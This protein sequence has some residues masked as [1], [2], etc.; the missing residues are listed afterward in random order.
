MAANNQQT[1]LA[2]IA[3][4]AANLLAYR[5]EWL[6]HDLVAGLSVAAVAAPIAVA[7]AD[8]AGFSPV[9]GLYASILPLVVYALFGTSRHLIVNPDAAICAMV[10]AILAPFAAHNTEVYSALSV[11]L[12]LLTG[13]L[14]IVAGFLRLGFVADFLGK[15]VLVGYMNGMAISI[16]LG[17][18]GKVCGFPIESER[19]VPRLVEFASK[20]SQTHLPTLAIGSLTFILIIGMRRYAPKLPAPLIAVSIAVALCHQFQLD[21]KGVLV[22]GAVPAG[23]PSLRL[24][25]FPIEH[26]DGFLAAAVGLALISFSS[27][28]IAARMFAGRQHTDLNVDREFVALGLCNIA[29]GF[30][31]GFA[32][33][34][35]DSRTA[36]NYTMGGKSQLSGLVAALVMASVLLFLT[37]LLRYFPIAALGAVLIVAAIGLVDIFSLRHLWHVSRSEFA[38][39][40]ITM[41]G[42]VAMDVLGGIL[43]AVGVAL[44]LLL[45]R[46]SRPGDATLGRVAGL[47]GFYAIAEEPNATMHQGLVIYRFE[48]AIVFFNAPYFRR[49]VLEIVAA[50]NHLKWLIVDGGPL[51]GVDTTGADMLGTLAVELEAAGIRLG[52]A[53][54]RSEVRALLGRSGALAGSGA[55]LVFPSLNSAV[56]AY[57]SS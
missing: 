54:L 47:S 40:I 19:I 48:A 14:C 9:V 16:F 34:G 13:I 25:K 33:S 4:G 50:D 29:A 35:T 41:V 15:P 1:L 52:F 22:V 38:V 12:A 44:L 3:P 20:L 17:Q 24:P 32:V 49:R 39:S 37:G 56:D 18:I 10:A 8:L 7:Y 57:L 43:L 23:L 46:T 5:R 42:V 26:M 53:G 51:N 36:V 31:Q 2:R 11:A 27:S 55:D 21:Q 45:K 30:S 28:I 6:R